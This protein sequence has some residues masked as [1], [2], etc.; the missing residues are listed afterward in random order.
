MNL[1]AANSTHLLLAL[2][3]TLREGE[4]SG[5]KGGKGGKGEREGYR[6]Y[7]DELPEEGVRWAPPLPA[8]KRAC[9]GR[10]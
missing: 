3:L 9:V 4:G 5:E 2:S 6:I 1:P 7:Y 10:H 8:G